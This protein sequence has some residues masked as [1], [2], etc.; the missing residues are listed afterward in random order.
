MSL[1]APLPNT[2][3]TGKCTKCR[4]TTGFT[5]AV[6][7]VEYT[8]VRYH[9]GAFYRASGGSTEDSMAENAVRFSCTRCGTRHA[10][11]KELT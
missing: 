10:V 11:P 1:N 4:K 3:A 6:D 8:A 2:T 9:S 5:L 7:K